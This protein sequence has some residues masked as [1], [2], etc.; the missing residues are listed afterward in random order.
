MW[1][2]I[3]SSFEAYCAESLGHK[4]G[5]SLSPPNKDVQQKQ[6]KI[7]GEK[8]GKQVNN[9]SQELK[10]QEDQRQTQQVNDAKEPT[11]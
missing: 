7:D 11:I 3:F 5:V 9:R 8:K 4:V 2:S 6:G 1:T 10:K